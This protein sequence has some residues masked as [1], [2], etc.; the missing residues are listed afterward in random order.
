MNVFILGT[1]SSTPQTSTMTG[2]LVV[3]S[4]AGISGNL[5][6]WGESSDQRIKEDI[7]DADLSECNNIVKQLVE[8]LPI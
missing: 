8:I 4:G 7:V 2:S 3:S 5:F 6:I 1:V